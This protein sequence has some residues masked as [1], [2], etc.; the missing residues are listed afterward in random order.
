MTHSRW[1]RLHAHAEAGT[2]VT[3][4]LS[5]EGGRAIF[6]PA[7]NPTN[8]GSVP[9]GSAAVTKTID[10]TN[11]GNMAGGAFI[12]VIS[13]GAVGSFHLIDESCTGILL[14]PAATCNMQVSF[15]PLAT[16]AKTARL[17]LFGEQDGG[18]QIVL[19]G[20]GLDTEP[21]TSE[22]PAAA[23]GAAAT[24]PH[25]K[26]GAHSKPQRGHGLHRRLRRDLANRRAIS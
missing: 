3:A 23:V 7:T 14:G 21:V 24:K 9:V 10:V 20:V 15:Q 11:V 2:V 5:G 1:G 12:A 17:S 4:D 22:T 8:F 6:E 26:H 25:A 18:T 13:G 16:G 19:L